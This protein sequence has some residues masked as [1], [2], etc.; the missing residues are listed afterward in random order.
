MKKH[1]D[2]TPKELTL[3][4]TAYAAGE[5]YYANL[6]KTEQKFATEM[7]RTSKKREKSKEMPSAKFASTM[8][9]L[10]VNEAFDAFLMNAENTHGSFQMHS[11]VHLSKLEGHVRKQDALAQD[12][13]KA[14]ARSRVVGFYGLLSGPGQH[15]NSSDTSD[16][17]DRAVYSDASDTE[18]QYIEELSG[19]TFMTRRPSSDANDGFAQDDNIWV[20]S[21]IMALDN[22]GIVKYVQAFPCKSGVKYSRTK[23]KRRPRKVKP[24]KCFWVPFTEQHV[25]S[26]TD[27]DVKFVQIRGSE[28]NEDSTMEEGD[29]VVYLGEDDAAFSQQHYRVRKSMSD[30]ARIHDELAR[31][32]TQFYEGKVD[33]TTRKRIATNRIVRNKA[34]QVFVDVGVQDWP[35]RYPNFWKHVEGSALN[36]KTRAGGTLVLS[37]AMERFGLRD[38]SQKS[39]IL[40]AR[41]RKL[42]TA[43]KSR[44]DTT[45]QLLT[46]LLREA[47][48]S[49]NKTPDQATHAKETL[50][51]TLHTLLNLVACVKLETVP[52]TSLLEG[53]F[54]AM[55][56]CNTAHGIAAVKVLVELMD[57]WQ[58]PHKM[59]R[60]LMSVANHTLS[61]LQKFVARPDLQATAYDGYLSQLVR[62]LSVFIRRHLSRI[63]DNSDFPM[64]QCLELIYRFTM[65][66][67]EASNFLQCLEVWAC[68]TDFVVEHEEEMKKSQDAAKSRRR[69][70]FNLVTPALVLVVRNV[71]PRL[72]I[73][74]GGDMIRSLD[75]AEPAVEARSTASLDMRND[76]SEKCRSVSEL[77]E[78]QDQAIATIAKMLSLPHAVDALIAV[79]RPLAQRSLTSLRSKN[80]ASGKSHTFHEAAEDLGVVFECAAAGASAFENP[81]HSEAALGIARLAL[82][83]AK[84][85]AQQSLYARGASFRRLHCSSFLCIENFVCWYNGVIKDVSSSAGSVFAGVSRTLEDEAVEAAFFALRANLVSPPPETIMSDAAKLVEITLLRSRTKEI[86]D[87]KAFATLRLRGGD[88]LT[89]LLRPIVSS[90]AGLRALDVVGSDIERSSANIERG[91]DILGRVILRFEKDKKRIKQMLL[92]SIGDAV[93]PISELLLKFLKFLASGASLLVSSSNATNRRQLRRVNLAL[94]SARHLFYLHMVL[95][96]S[97]GKELGKDY[98]QAAVIAICDNLSSDVIARL[99]PLSASAAGVNAAGRK[100]GLRLVEYCLRLLC[101]AAGD[102]SKQHRSLVVPICTLVVSRVFPSLARAWAAGV[103]PIEVSDAFFEV[104]R[105]LVLNHHGFF[106]VSKVAALSKRVPRS[107]TTPE[108]GRLWGA[109]FECLG[110]FLSVPRAPPHSTRAVLTFLCEANKTHG[111]LSCLSVNMRSAFQ[112]LFL[113]MIAGRSH[114]LLHDS[115]LKSLYAVVAADTYLFYDKT[116]PVFF[117]NFKNL[118]QAQIKELV[119]RVRSNGTNDYLFGPALLGAVN[120]A[121]CCAL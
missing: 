66:Q 39:N 99:M 1:V 107:Y 53:L 101:T 84:D 60:Y 70:A 40:S 88:D 38:G 87:F 57:T 9:D 49:I 90:L 73:S 117:G 24:S 55:Q 32:L 86:Y 104:I 22:T 82:A 42:A 45:L 103:I 54:A 98:M 113:R 30:V 10:R 18:Q 75:S 2:L 50:L 78:F 94:R 102:R 92:V 91:C 31:V 67:T 8:C 63:F 15:Q 111:T 36:I 81:R 64:R 12:P 106:V 48:T 14:L 27:D 105:A 114:T 16:D 109:M 5:Q 69:A 93:K 20:E 3:M 61:L 89:N 77:R 112:N 58:V 83:T 85:S 97:L 110:S 26:K 121:S 19:Q 62:F 4:R 56:M 115:I 68:F 6:E 25:V 41:R 23:K 37:M 65:S 34:A 21:H 79:L 95:I 17:P 72:L 44:A 29:D 120:D 52:D 108:A 33:A 11:T 51:H 80:T 46:R 71:V 76:E 43:I 100:N 119:K 116:L 59:L 47:L 74:S 35:E 96:R 28:V 13:F 7:S 118:S